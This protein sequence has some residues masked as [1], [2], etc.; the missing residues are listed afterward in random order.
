MRHPSNL[1]TGL[2]IYDLDIFMLPEKLLLL[3]Q[4]KLHSIHYH[5]F[6]VCHVRLSKLCEVFHFWKMEYTFC[7]IPLIT[8]TLL[9]QKEVEIASLNM[10]E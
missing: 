10:V 8:G 1:D 4:S 5:R 3:K 9:N 7:V 2:G 6:H